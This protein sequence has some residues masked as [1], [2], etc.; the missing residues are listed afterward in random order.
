MQA[1]VAFIS[2]KFRVRSKSLSGCT[3]LFG[4]LKVKKVDLFEEKSPAKM[5]K[6]CQP[7]LPYLETGSSIDQL[8]RCKQSRDLLFLGIQRKQISVRT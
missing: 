1:S 8:H 7:S 2:S 6:K 4:V 3:P 5:Q